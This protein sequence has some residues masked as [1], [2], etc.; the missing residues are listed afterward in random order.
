MTVETKHLKLEPYNSLRV[1]EAQKRVEHDSLLVL[2]AADRSVPIYNK[3]LD[4]KLVYKRWLHL[5]TGWAPNC[6][7]RS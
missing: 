4:L 7:A 5:G 2:S 1:G 3:R 6:N